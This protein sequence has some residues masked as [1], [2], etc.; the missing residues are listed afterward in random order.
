MLKAKLW[1]NTRVA[2]LSFFKCPHCRDFDIW[3]C[4]TVGILT[5]NLSKCQNFPGVALP[6]QE[7]IDRC[8]TMA[9]VAVSQPLSHLKR[10]YKAIDLRLF[11]QVAP[12]MLSEQS[13][14][15]LHSKKAMLWS[16]K[17]TNKDFTIE[18]K[19]EAACYVEL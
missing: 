16:S 7:D 3:D 12:K 4:P 1:N 15:F 14:R 10:Q 13:L 11:Q 6:P 9:M 18:I 2:T 5:I 8:I 17:V 19:N